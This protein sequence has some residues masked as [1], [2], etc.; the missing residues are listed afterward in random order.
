MGVVILRPMFG[1]LLCGA[2]VLL[3]PRVAF[4]GALSCEEADAG[5]VTIDGMLDD[6]EGVAK[7]RAGGKDADQ[8]FDVRCLVEGDTLAVSIDVRD[9]YLTRIHKASAKLQVAEDHLDVTLGNVVLRLWPGKNKEAPRRLLVTGKK[10]KKLPK[11]VQVED[12]QE[13]KGWSIEIAVPVG[14]LGAEDSVD[15]KVTFTDADD[16]TVHTTTTLEDSL[17]L[18]LGAAAP[19]VTAADTL[20]GFLRDTHLK[21]KDL[22][23]DQTAGGVHYV[24]GGKFLGVVG[25][26]YSY[27]ELPV[28]SAKDVKKLA[29]AD[30]RG[31]G[32]REVV[33]VLD[34]AGDGS[35]RE[36]VAVFGAEGDAL[37]QLFAVEVHLE[38]A[39]NAIDDTWS[40][41][42]RKVKGKA[43]G[44]ELRV[45]AGTATGWDE[46]SF[47][48]TPTDA[49][50]IHLPWDDAHHGAVYWLDGTTL[51]SQVLAKK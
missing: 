45:E 10:T 39:G 51:R 6:W 38:A 2:L 26:K 12:T 37:Q 46:D 50:A 44:Q 49:E 29:L 4:A 9:E 15:G 8:S 36:V 5:T 23:L 48:E 14:K 34:Q 3:T 13:P 11:W 7:D 17:T 28:D 43:K 47:E 33:C 40:L 30:L 25:D 21:K 24:A 22:T 32:K 20:D 31:D 1:K 41:E 27:V 16:E 35:S 18:T 42:P 19:K